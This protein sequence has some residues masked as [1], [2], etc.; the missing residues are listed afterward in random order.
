MCN[1]YIYIYIYIYT[2]YINPKNELMKGANF[3]H[4]DTNLGKLSVIIIRC[5]IMGKTF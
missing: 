3:L 2:L 1:V 4:A 5:S